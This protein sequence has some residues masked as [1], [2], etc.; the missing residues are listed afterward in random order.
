MSFHALMQQDALPLKKVLWAKKLKALRSPAVEQPGEICSPAGLITKPFISKS[1]LWETL[2]WFMALQWHNL[3]LP[4]LSDF[5]FPLD[6]SIPC[7]EL[8]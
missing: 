3:R 5:S 2:A 1:S 8:H 7:H 4:S 6:S